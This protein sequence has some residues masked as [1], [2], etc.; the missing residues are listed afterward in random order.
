MS[1]GGHGGGRKKA[2]HDEEHENHE[3]WAVSYADMMTVLVGLFIVLYAMSQV[4]QTKF[5]AL[6]GSLAAGFGNASP[7]VLTGASGVMKDAGAVPASIKPAGATSP[8]APVSELTPEAKALADARVEAARLKELEAKVEANLAAAGLPGRVT[9]G[10]DARGLVIGMVASDFFFDTGSAA[11][12]PGA[13]T[14]LDAAAPVLASV[15]DEI[16]VEGHADSTPISGRYATNWELSA[17]RATQVLRHLV[18]VDGIAGDRIS[19]VSFGDARPIAGAA[20]DQLAANRRVDL[21]IHSP[22]SETV[23]ALLPVVIATGG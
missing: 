1:G 15:P 10:I 8:I 20:G 5:E 17:D 2:A 18:E 6:R 22:Q 9:Y 11:L 7:T 3:R 23:R 16:S 21:V 13:Q 12:K 4:N 14:V 19:A